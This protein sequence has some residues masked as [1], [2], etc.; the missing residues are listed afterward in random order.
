VL[1]YIARVM[2]MSYRQITKIIGWT[3]GMALAVFMI[4]DGKVE[5]RTSVG[6]CADWSG[7]RFDSRHHFRTQ[8]KR[9]NISDEI[10][11]S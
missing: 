11:C 7:H 3:G 2:E 8:I 4:M 5:S 1:G 9:T 10:R 6:T